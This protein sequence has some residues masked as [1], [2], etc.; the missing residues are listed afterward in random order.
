MI[1]AFEPRVRGSRTG[2]SDAQCSIACTVGSPRLSK[3]SMQ[4]RAELTVPDKHAVDL[5]PQARAVDLVGDYGNEGQQ[6]A[7]KARSAWKN[8]WPYEAWVCL[9]KLTAG[10]ARECRQRLATYWLVA[11]GNARLANTDSKERSRC[12][13][14]RVAQHVGVQGNYTRRRGCGSARIAPKIFG[15]QRC[16]QHSPWDLVLE[17]A[18]ARTQG[19]TRPGLQARE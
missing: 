2:M 19:S 16:K 4:I 5:N 15:S 8:K 9:T 13:L 3:W 12:R 7:L 18:R 14:V 1:D 17:G 10:E 6:H 11:V